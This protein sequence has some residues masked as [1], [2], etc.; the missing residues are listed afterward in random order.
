MMSR[1]IALF[2][3]ALFSPAVLAQGVL[4]VGDNGKPLNLD[5]ETGTLADWTVDGEAFASQPVKGDTV[6]ARGRGM[7]SGHQGNYW[8]GGYEKTLSDKPVGTLTSAPFK[9]THRYA[10]FMVAGG[11]T[12]KTAV[13]LVVEGET[14]PFFQS[15]G[16][17]N[18]QLWP[19]MVD[20][21]KQQGKTIRIRIVDN[22]TGNWGHVNFDNFR[23][24]DEKPQL[25][26]RPGAGIALAPAGS[27]PPATDTFKHAGL[28]AEDAVKAM[29]LPP[30]FKAQV[31]AA[32]P[33][34]IN[35]IAFTI[36]AR[37][38]LW[39]A[40]SFTYPIRAAEGEGKDSII[41]LEDTNG[42]GKHD[43]RT[44]FAEK[45]NLVSGIEVG[46]GG[47]YVG[48]APYLLH[49]P[50][51]LSADEP[52]PTGEPKILL[53][54]WGYQ[55]THETLNSF[56]WGPDGWLYGCHGVFTKS[57]VGKPGTPPEQRQ[58]I[59][60]G[61]WRYHPTKHIFERFAEGTSNPWG[62]DFDEHGQMFI[63]ACVIPHL[64]HVIQG[65][66][67]Q[68]QAGQHNNPYTFDDIKQIGDHVHYLGATPH[69]GNN[70]S[71]SAGG[72][73]AHSGLMVYLGDNW[74][75]EYRGK[76]FM[77]NI[78]GARINM[79]IP[80][81]K[82][83]GY[84][85]RHGKDFLLANDRA[86]Q[87]IAMRYAPDGAVYFADWYD[88]QQCHTRNP[89]DHDRTTG[90]I[91]KVTY[92][93]KT[94]KPL[95]FNKSSDKDLAVGAWQ[96]H[97]SAR[98]CRLLL[99][100]R[101]A[102]GSLQKDSLSPLQDTVKSCPSP[103]IRMRA[104]WT[105]HV[106]GLLREEDLLAVLADPAEHQTDING[107]AIV[108]SWAIQLACEA[109][110]PNRDVISRIEAV[111]KSS[112]PPVVRLAAASAA[113]RLEPSQR[114]N[115][116]GSLLSH[117]EDATDHNLPLMYWYALEPLLDVD[118][119][120]ALDLAANT[121]IPNILNFSARK[122]AMIG[123][124]KNLDLLAAFLLN[125]K[126]AAG[127]G[128]VLRGMT[129]G[130][131]GRRD[132]AAPKDWDKVAAALGNV[133]DAQVTEGVRSLSVTFGSKTAMADMRKVLSD[134]SAKAED[135]TAALAALVTAKDPDLAP[136]LLSLLDDAAVRAPAI[137]GLANYDDAKIP[138][139]LL[140]RYGS[141]PPAE[142]KDALATLAS[143]PAF[144]VA[145]LEAVDKQVPKADFS[146]DLLR[147]LRTIKG[148][149]VA[150]LL[151]KYWVAV[152]ETDADK[153]AKMAKYKRLVSGQGPAANLSRGREL[154]NTT[155]ASCHTLFG[156]GG[157]VGPDITGSD[158]GNLDYLLH[159]VVD[160]NAVIPVDYQAW[161][162][163]TKDDRTIIGIVKQQD[164]Q[165]VT[166]QTATEIA[167]INRADVAK[168]KP[169]PLSM[170]PEGAL[171][172]L[173]E[174][175]VRNLIAYLR[176]PKQVPLNAAQPQQ[177]Q[178][179]GRGKAN[180]RANAPEIPLLGGGELPAGTLFNGKDLTGWQWQM[181]GLWSVEDG[182]IVGKTATG[183][184]K[185]QFLTS[186]QSFKDFRLIVK[187]KLT[188][189]KENS[190]IQFRSVR[191]PG[192]HEMRGCQAD[193]GAGWWG[194]LYE[195]S[196]RGLLFPKKG[197]QFD[198]TPFLKIDDWNTYEILAVGGKVR[199]AIN[200]KPCTV[201]DDEQ[202]A[203]EGVFGLQVHSG[204]P[205]DVRWK[206]FELEIDPKFELKTVK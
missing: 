199:T 183:L 205:M 62:L 33:D 75:D 49:I 86:S 14:K 144:A 110:L 80:E 135:R 10:T 101:A 130:L 54:G 53:D 127:R 82:G 21:E 192:S 145:L 30:G 177:P 50:T 9:V 67:Y 94:S 23:F 185:N 55:D 166:I 204:G 117:S 162:L 58:Y 34:V 152:N 70:K 115:L 6:T 113:L 93:E 119:S 200:G 28:S 15:S 78:H 203:K 167:T 138:A 2:L 158:R 173:S 97:A 26:A 104:M 39:V 136:S 74:P 69:S 63:E 61:V 31:F 96:R 43:K 141:L 143:R 154:F 202:I 38:R 87:I 157:K 163:D 105:L 17:E 98:T 42:D 150:D 68:R 175:D 188:P 126:Y 161:Q 124:E 142:K 155:C 8:V 111:A 201:L 41:I 91:F 122:L 19:V 194:K 178:P 164:A 174:A 84:V 46:F 191:I 100:E 148:K 170:M 187:M 134:P 29:T 121:K 140:S 114:W 123:G 108:R 71:D 22:A 133:A 20:L 81:P 156:E 56:M 186:T 65:A 99:Q 7:I 165:T 88:L 36:D 16:V 12:A 89:K 193:A 107:N 32:E 85:G 132:I 64:W 153:L 25:K 128:D 190:G 90:R 72:G 92:G 149:E 37:G 40:Q 76:I 47:V 95:A 13:Q 147:Q 198:A 189:N 179:A 59:D 172:A 79:D 137:R 35:P 195:E 112:N 169:S 109:G 11:S 118:A 206:D 129:T 48:A 171:D 120:R 159:N 184:K 45:L 102:A 4:P 139:A 18:E 1:S 151:N 106:T 52:K 66:R 24:H 57:L 160:P 44:V 125:D 3:V 116:V 60:A 182:A 77:N 103:N 5:F 180:P 131:K 146:P 197:E 51:D 176:S 27:N 168:L 83:S 196:A 181:D 73:H